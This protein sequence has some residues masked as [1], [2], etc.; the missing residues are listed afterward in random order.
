V[1]DETRFL[2]GSEIGEC[3]AVAKRKGRD[4]FVAVENGATPRSLE[5]PLEFLGGG[6]YSMEAFSDA[7][8]RPDGYVRANRQ[9]TADD[10][11]SLDVKPSGGFV[12]RLRPHQD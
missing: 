11:L 9:V 12:A 2:S 7:T 3:V 1:Y 4:W 8:D 6:T 5:I 10:S